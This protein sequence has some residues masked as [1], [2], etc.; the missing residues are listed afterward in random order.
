MEDRRKLEVGKYIE[1]NRKRRSE[2]IALMRQIN[3]QQQRMMMAVTKMLTEE[4]QTETEEKRGVWGGRIAGSK[5]YRRGN[6][7]WYR[8]YLG[9]NPTYPAYVFRRRLEFRERCTTKL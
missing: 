3:G 1:R 5:N 2:E 7:N 9:D 4:E 8:D 6:S